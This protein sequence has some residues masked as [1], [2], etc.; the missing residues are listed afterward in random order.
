MSVPVLSNTIKL[1]LPLTFTRGGDM[2]KILLRFSLAI[3]KAAP[4]VMAAGS[5]GGTV[6]VI[7]SKDR[8]MISS[9]LR[10]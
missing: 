5:A 9:T 8:S 10:F 1:T 4:A 6:I 2:Q 7:R 3:A